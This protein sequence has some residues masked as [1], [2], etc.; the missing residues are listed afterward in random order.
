MEYARHTPS[1]RV[2]IKQLRQTNME[3][4]MQG[5]PSLL[6]S[7]KQDEQRWPAS[8]FGCYMARVYFE[9]A[10]VRFIM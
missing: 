9:H 7:Q 5:I 4:D 2:I 8:P 3:R 1:I 10:R 6:A